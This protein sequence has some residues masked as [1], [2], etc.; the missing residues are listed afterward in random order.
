MSTHSFGRQ[1]TPELIAQL[2]ASGADNREKLHEALCQHFARNGNPWLNGQITS[3]DKWAKLTADAGLIDLVAHGDRVTRCKAA[4]KG[5]HV[6]PVF[7]YGVISNGS[8]ASANTRSL[9]QATWG[10]D[11]TPATIWHAVSEGACDRFR[12]ADWLNL[13]LAGIC[14][15]MTPIRAESWAKKAGIA[16]AILRFPLPCGQPPYIHKP[17]EYRKRFYR[18][19][20]G[21]MPKPQPAQVEQ[22]GIEACAE[23]LQLFNLIPQDAPPVGSGRVHLW[24]T[25]E[26]EQAA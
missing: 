6:V 1:V 17:G 12:L 19:E 20:P 14:E 25:D 18:Y 4:A 9:R 5:E 22:Q 15:P 11:A 8:A 26:M 24:D 13:L 3:I 16:G 21:V 23:I 2:V 10:R 7:R